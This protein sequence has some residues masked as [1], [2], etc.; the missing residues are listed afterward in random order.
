MV[1]SEINHMPQVMLLVSEVSE[2]MVLQELMVVTQVVHLRG[3]LVLQGL[4]VEQVERVMLV[5]SLG[6]ILPLFE[7]IHMLQVM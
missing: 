2:L 7:N 5:L 1:S 4:L 6:T 3:L